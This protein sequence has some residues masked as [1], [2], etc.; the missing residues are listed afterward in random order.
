MR[1]ALLLSCVALATGTLSTSSALADHGWVQNYQMW[2]Q[3]MAG[4]PVDPPK[5]FDGKTVTALTRAG[6][7][8]VYVQTRQGRIYEISLDEPCG[9]L[10]Q[11]RR[12]TLQARAGGPVCTSD[13]P[14]VIAFTPSGKA[15]CRAHDVRA[16]TRAEIA[17]Q[18]ARQ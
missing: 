4:P 8:A 17:A 3:A 10:D 15:Q 6:E 11:A 18:A 7:A 9:A 13:A 5:C 14:Q 12:V 1:P 2:T 16:L